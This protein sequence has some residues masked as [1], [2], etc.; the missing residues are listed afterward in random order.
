MSVEVLV[1]IG[2]IVVLLI[3]FILGIYGQAQTFADQVNVN[4]AERM[5]LALSEAVD[6]VVASGEGSNLSI[7]VSTPANVEEIRAEGREIVIRL[8]VVGG[9]TEIVKTTRANITSSNLER[10]RLPGTYKISVVSE[11]SPEGAHARIEPA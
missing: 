11:R 10:I 3:P 2:I 4:Q 5:A 6:V 9:K 1:V 8:S 7:Y